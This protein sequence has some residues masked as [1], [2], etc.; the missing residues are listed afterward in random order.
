MTGI[1]TNNSRA[2]NKETTLVLIIQQLYLIYNILVV[3]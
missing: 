1:T 3:N 2:A